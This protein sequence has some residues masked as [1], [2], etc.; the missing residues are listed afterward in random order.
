MPHP[1]SHGGGRGRAVC[2]QP[3]LTFDAHFAALP[4][5]S[6]QPATTLELF[7]TRLPFLPGI[8]QHKTRSLSEYSMGDSMDVAQQQA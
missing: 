5:P 7:R 2:H 4:R 8:L 1:E 3:Y 6:S